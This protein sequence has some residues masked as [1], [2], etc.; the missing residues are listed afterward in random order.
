MKNQP[1]KQRNQGLE[2]HAMLRIRV[3]SPSK[4]PPP[5]QTPTRAPCQQRKTAGSSRR[6]GKDRLRR[7][8][9]TRHCK[10]RPQN[11]TPH[12]AN[13]TRRTNTAGVLAAGVSHQKLT[14]R[15]GLRRQ[16]HALVPHHRLIGDPVLARLRVRPRKT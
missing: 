6:Y 14:V 15:K 7:L 16:Y 11:D 12:P 3:T 5:P 1:R 13:D 2:Y 9:S 10:R 8:V 4:A